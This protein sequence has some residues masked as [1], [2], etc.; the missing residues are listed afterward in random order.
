MVKTVKIQTI[1]MLFPIISPKLDFILKITKTT[2]KYLYQGK[3]LYT[4]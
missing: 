1:H 4:F 2:S 3:Y